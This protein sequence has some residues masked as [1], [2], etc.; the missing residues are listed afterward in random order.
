MSV[1]MWVKCLSNCPSIRWPIRSF[2]VIQFCVCFCPSVCLP[3]QIL[4][5]YVSARP[6]VCP[7]V[8]LF[9]YFSCDSVCNSIS[10]YVFFPSVRPSEHPSVIRQNDNAVC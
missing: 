4:S 1:G 6:P 7:S 10:L 5:V 9:A 3:V 8:R 2:V